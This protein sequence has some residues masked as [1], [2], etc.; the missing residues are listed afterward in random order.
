MPDPPISAPSFACEEGGAHDGPQAFHACY[1]DLLHTSPINWFTTPPAGE[2]Q[3]PGGH[4]LAAR[5]V[6]PGFGPGMPLLGYLLDWGDCLGR[7]RRKHAVASILKNWPRARE[8]TLAHQ[9]L[10]RFT[11]RFDAT[12]PLFDQYLLNVEAFVGYRWTAILLRQWMDEARGIADGL[13]APASLTPDAAL[14]VAARWVI[15]AEARWNPLTSEPFPYT[16]PMMARYWIGPT[17]AAPLP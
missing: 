4:D 11:W 5:G 12:T 15:D 9:L 17:V 1:T 7:I 2:P 8:R 13:A 3:P 14:S 16:A 10:S 6:Y